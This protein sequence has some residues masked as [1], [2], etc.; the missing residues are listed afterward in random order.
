[1]DVAYMTNAWGAVVAHCAAANNVNGAYYLS[2]GGD[3]EAISEIAEAGFNQ[4][5]IFDGNLL[6][7]EDRPGDFKRL[8]DDNGVGLLAVYSAANFIYDEILQE[9]LYRI[10]KAAAFAAGLGAT[11]LVLGGGATRY[12]GIRED[13]YK[14]LAAG[15]DKVCDIAEEA[16]VT[17]SYHPHMGSL[18]ENLGQLDKVAP[19]TRIALCPDMGHL[20]LG[21]SDPIAVCQKYLDRIA[22]VHLKDV[23]K[24]GMFCPL[25]EGVIDFP[26]LM[27]VL[28]SADRELIYAIECDGWYG[29]PRQGAKITYSYLKEGLGF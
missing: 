22:Y 7:Y 9:E 24:D 25:G 15:L 29:D 11:Q 18:V 3:A 23:T 12:D 19:Y 5:E 28:R 6:A 14:K 8:L 1:M 2:T 26:A 16:G 4:I 21:G 13:D 17:A 20:V 10:K 27:D